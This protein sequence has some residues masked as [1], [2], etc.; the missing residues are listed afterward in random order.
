MRKMILPL[1]ITS[2]MVTSSAL[3]TF[4]NTFDLNASNWQTWNVKN[5]GSLNWETPQ[6][7]DSGFIGSTVDNDAWRT[8]GMQPAVGTVGD[9]TG[10]MLHVDTKIAGNVTSAGGK[11]TVRFYVGSFTGG[12]NYYVSKDLY[13][14]DINNDTR[15]TGHNIVMDAANFLLWP[16]QASRNKTFGQVIAA[17]EDIGVIFTDGADRF[18]SNKYLGF[19]S[20][21]GATIY[22]DNFGTFGP[23]MECVPEP[24]TLVLLI[25]GSLVHRYRSKV[26][27]A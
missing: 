8:Y 22:L 10:Q 23:A 19:S 5:S 15:W 24:A 7:Y 20:L 4:T 2:L 17:P 12:N 11:P 16:N 3:A 9:L 21:G 1:V 6:W 26:K 14:W 18:T 25:M 27:T 13:S